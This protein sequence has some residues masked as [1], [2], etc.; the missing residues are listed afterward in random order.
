MTP[1]QI[2]EFLKLCGQLGPIGTFI[3]ISIV[4]IVGWFKLVKPMRNGNLASHCAVQRDF[5]EGKFRG[6]MDKIDRNHAEFDRRMTS[7]EEDRAAM[8]DDI[9]QVSI[10]VGVLLDRTNH[11][12]R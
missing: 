11:V 10:N 4:G 12:A 2:A 1:D 8:R 3:G 5:C 7:S 6:I 9:K